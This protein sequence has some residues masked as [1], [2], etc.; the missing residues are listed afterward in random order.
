MLSHVHFHSGMSPKKTCEIRNFLEI[1]VNV[2][3]FGIRSVGSRHFSAWNL[4]SGLDESCPTFFPNP[5]F[6]D[7]HCSSRFLVDSQENKSIFQLTSS[8]FSLVLGWLQQT[9]Q[10]VLP[11]EW[12]FPLCLVRILPSPCLV[13]FI[14]L[15]FKCH[16]KC[17]Q[18]NFTLP[19]R[20]P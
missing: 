15:T 1:T 7:W 10:A 13:P 9:K 6:P 5:V 19:F 11:Q 14:E 8:H 3:K 2:R 12:K 4:E 20:C 17:V 18:R 16:V